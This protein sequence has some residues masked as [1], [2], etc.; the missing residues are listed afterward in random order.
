MRRILPCWLFDGPGGVMRPTLAPLHPQRLGRV[1]ACLLEMVH[2]HYAHA[3]RR[4]PSRPPCATRQF[5]IQSAARH[6]TLPDAPDRRPRLPRLTTQPDRHLAANR[7]VIGQAC[8]DGARCRCRTQSDPGEHLNLFGQ[9]SE[10]QQT[11]ISHGHPRGGGGHKDS[12][13]WCFIIP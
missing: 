8:L 11:E 2:S 4:M 1:L 6:D 3:V 13:L 5:Y 7:R 9:S 10:G 12:N